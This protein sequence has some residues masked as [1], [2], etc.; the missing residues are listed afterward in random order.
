MS[1]SL[2]T[3]LSITEQQSLSGGVD[4]S[5]YYYKFEKDKWYCYQDYNNQYGYNYYKCDPK[6]YGGGGYSG[7]GGGY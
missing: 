7:G 6:G 2:F 1:R 4:F 3:E 5:G